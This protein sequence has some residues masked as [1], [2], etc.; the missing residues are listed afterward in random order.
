MFAILISEETLP[1]IV[2]TH[3]LTQAEIDWLPKCINK[4][5]YFV[6]GF[7]DLRGQVWP[8]IF[9]PRYLLKNFEH[10][11]EKIKTDWDQIV[12]KNPVSPPREIHS[13]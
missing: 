7:V 4:D 8:W 3:G 13:P 10:D 11:E 9:L 1:K 5:R 6:T 2:E 12:R